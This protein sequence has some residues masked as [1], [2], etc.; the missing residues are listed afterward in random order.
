MDPNADDTVLD[1]VMGTTAPGAAFTS[2]DHLLGDLD[3]RASRAFDGDP[4]TAWTPNF[5]SQS[6]RWI[7]VQLAGPVTVDHVDLSVIADGRH[8]VPTQFML[9]TGD[10]SRSFTIPQLRDGTQPGTTR[11]VTVPFDPLTGQHFRLFVDAVRPKFTTVA[12]GTPQ[13]EAPV[14]IA[15]VGLAGVPAPSATNLLSTACRSDLLE[16]NGAPTSVRLVGTA[17]QARSGLAIEPCSGSLALHAGSNIVRST[18]G[19]DTGLDVDRLVFSSGVDGEATPP[20]VLGAPI[21]ESGANVRVVDSSPDSYGLEVRT[22]GKPFWLVLGES[23][24]AGWDATVSEGSV[25]AR[26]LVNGFANGWLVTPRG[27]GTLTMELRWTPQRFVWLGLAASVVAALACVAL[28]VVTWSRRRSAGASDAAGSLA[29][30]PT[31]WS[32]FDYPGVRPSTAALLALAIGAAIG[33][34]LFSRPWIGAVVGVATAIAARVARGRIVFTAGVP[35]ALALARIT[36][37]DDL[38]WLAVALLAADLVTWWVRERHLP[39]ETAESSPV[40][41]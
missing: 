7:E 32:P 8:S 39:S 33:T 31:L 14:G 20:T 18:P 1:A 29:D 13:I 15:E 35:V 10:G 17:T 2:A 23:A 30:D 5:G 3:A 38:A 27:A 6:G 28:V 22:D 25:S 4:T 12:R 11:T 34:S 19:L 9:Q 41:V 26:Q 16:V 24:N 40:S 36:R 21:E 37:F